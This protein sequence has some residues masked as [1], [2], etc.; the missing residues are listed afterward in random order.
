M[1]I[2]I[3]LIET[4]RRK[5]L[6]NEITDVDFPADLKAVGIQ[7]DVRVNGRKSI[8]FGVI[9][10]YPAAQGEPDPADVETIVRG[11]ISSTIDASIRNGEIVRRLRETLER[12]ET[13]AIAAL[14]N[15]S[16]RRFGTLAT[17]WI[18]LKIILGE[19]RR[20]NPFA[21][22]VRQAKRIVEGDDAE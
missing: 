7:Y 18:D 8:P 6:S 12:S 2:E 22:F 19:S 4:G 5:N 16:F 17:F 3:E 20:G 13:D 11:Q 14:S 10:P 1:K 15:S 9:I 21:E